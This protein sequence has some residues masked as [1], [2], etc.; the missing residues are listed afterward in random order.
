MLMKVGFLRVTCWV[1]FLLVTGGPELVTTWTDRR[2]TG[3]V[4]AEL[5]VGC[6][7]GFNIFIGFNSSFSFLERCISLQRKIRLSTRLN[8]QISMSISIEFR[9]FCFLNSLEFLF[10]IFRLFFHIFRGF[11]FTFLFRDS[12]AKSEKI[13][14]K[15]N[16]YFSLPSVSEKFPVEFSNYFFSGFSTLKDRF[17]LRNIWILD[18]ENLHNFNA[19]FLHLT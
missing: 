6:N 9:G 14:K 12:E 11:D 2:Q 3:L 8:L 7:R 16:Y 17:F 15:R 5:L 1:V 18:I 10:S 19:P 13:R 4:G